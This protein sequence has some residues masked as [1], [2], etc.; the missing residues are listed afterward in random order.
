MAMNRRVSGVLGMIGVCG[1]EAYIRVLALG[2][3]E[4]GQLVDKGAVLV[5]LYPA[6]PVGSPRRNDDLQSIRRHG[7]IELGL[8]IDIQALR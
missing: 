2:T 8:P 4:F 6:L 5:V 3:S 1:A 7:T